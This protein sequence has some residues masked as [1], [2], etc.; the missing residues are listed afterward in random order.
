MLQGCFCKM[1]FILLT[2]QMHMTEIN[3]FDLDNVDHLLD[4]NSVTD[5][6]NF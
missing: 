5:Y 1:S 4:I 2:L 3:M 6:T